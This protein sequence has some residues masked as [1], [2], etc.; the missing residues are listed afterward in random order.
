LAGIDIG[1]GWDE[2]RIGSVNLLL[3]K[4]ISD[5]DGLAIGINNKANFDNGFLEH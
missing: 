3:Q 5:L 1:I 2:E 4:G